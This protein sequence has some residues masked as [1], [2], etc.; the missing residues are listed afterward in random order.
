MK[1]LMGLSD[2]PYHGAVSQSHL[3]PGGNVV[4]L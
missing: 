4:R 2:V 1:V 3:T